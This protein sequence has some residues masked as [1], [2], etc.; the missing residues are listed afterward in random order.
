MTKQEIDN[1]KVEARIKE[2]EDE[3]EA[4]INEANQRVFGY[5]ASIGELKKLLEPEQKV[6]ITETNVRK[7]K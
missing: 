7:F 3:L 5:S 6:T 4:F 2:L 1:E